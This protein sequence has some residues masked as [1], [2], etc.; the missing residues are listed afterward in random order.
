MKTNIIFSLCLFFVYGVAHSSSS[1]S[2]S[3]PKAKN[4]SQLIS[5]QEQRLKEITSERACIA[6]QLEKMLQED[7]ERFLD[8]SKY[9]ELVGLSNRLFD[10]GYQLQTTQNIIKRASLKTYEETYAALEQEVEE[11]YKAE[12]KLKKIA[13]EKNV[14]NE[15]AK[16]ETQVKLKSFSN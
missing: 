12:Q 11:Q 16:R 4:F 3:E 6:E 2:S 10:E 8:D 13:E 5:D 1:S 7:P 15:I 14:E 9:R